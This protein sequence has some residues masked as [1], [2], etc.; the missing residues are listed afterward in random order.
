MGIYTVVNQ[1][2]E[3]NKLT[4]I[5]GSHSVRTLNF[6]SILMVVPFWANNKVSLLDVGECMTV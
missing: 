4:Y 5:L 1:L 6:C 2:F 3:Y